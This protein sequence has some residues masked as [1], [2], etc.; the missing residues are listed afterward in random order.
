MTA[1]P[2][3]W[4]E[5]MF[6]R[7]HH[8]QAAHRY[9]ASDL[10]RGTRWNLHHDWGLR[11]IE[12][13]R[14]ALGNSRLVIRS[15]KARL[16]DG[17][18]ISLP[19]EG[20]LPALDLKPLLERNPSLTVFLALPV[21]NLGRARRLFTGAV[22]RALILR[23]GGCAFPG[24]DRPHRW[25]DGHH[26]RAWADGGTTDLDNGVLL[27]RFHHRQIHHSGWDVRLGTDRKPEFLPPTHLDPLR[28][29]RRNTHH[30]AAN[31]GAATHHPRT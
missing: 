17:T 23:D 5:G 18:L 8:F 6:L 20:D 25:C 30:R 9:L 31:H 10:T 2:V 16:R 12:L 26:L 1:R 13:D 3:H 4:H 21:L 19:D 7:P 24:C 14:D 22:R 28:R 29:P 11:H 27:C 15:L